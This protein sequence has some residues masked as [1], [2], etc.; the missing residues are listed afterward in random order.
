MATINL[1]D[2]W[3]SSTG[4]GV[5]DDTAIFQQA[6]KLA[7]GGT[8]YIPK[9]SVAY[10]LSSGLQIPSN[11]HIIFEAGTNVQATAGFPID[12]ALF[13]MSGVS[14]VTIDGNGATFGMSKVQYPTGYVGADFRVTNCSNIT[15]NNLIVTSTSG[16]DG[17]YINN[18]S[19][20]TMSGCAASNCMRNG[21]TLIGA[22]GALIENCYFSKNDGG[23]HIEPNGPTDV[24]KNIVFQNCLS[25]NNGDYGISLGLD[26]YKYETS[27]T[28][29][30]VTFTNC[31]TRNN[32]VCGLYLPVYNFNYGIG[33]TIDVNN[34]TSDGD[35]L[36]MSISNSGSTSPIVTVDKWKILN[37]T[38][39]DLSI[40][41]Y[42][43]AAWIRDMS[44]VTSGRI[45]FTQGTFT[46]TVPTVG[47]NTATTTTTTPTTT[48]TTT[49][50]TTTTSTTTTT[51]T[52]TSN[53]TY[54]TT[55]SDTINGTSGNDVIYGMG[56][57]DFL[58]GNDGNDIL[59]GGAGEGDRL[60]GGKGADTYMF[61]LGDGN[62]KITGS[63][64]NNQDTVLFNSGIKVSDLSVK[65]LSNRD[66]VISCNSTDSLTIQNWS[67]STG[68]A[69]N[70]FQFAGDSSKYKLTMTNGVASW[71]KV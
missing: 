33:G 42:Q 9:S 53:I 1:G 56:G 18:V 58:Y 41:N 31:T 65:L 7:A 28:D 17:F 15:L 3:T 70:T 54:G 62:D 32:A 26:K 36:A 25:E 40:V 46:S 67:Y 19:N 60:T 37:P 44:G 38:A 5:T 64:I 50:P 23:I 8:L 39:Y 43:G 48:T 45:V 10:S 68:T 63:S 55:A 52:P 21:L 14:N 30:S 29:V 47:V 34:Y 71:A 35:K 24:L 16:G 49:T 27:R 59:W 69:L 13:K 22:N 12:T 61:G 57:Q 66:L 2:L 4:N 20:L 6:L 51:T 11:T